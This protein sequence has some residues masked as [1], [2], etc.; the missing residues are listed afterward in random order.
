MWLLEWIRNLV[1]DFYNKLLSVLKNWVEVLIKYILW[2]V[3]CIMRLAFETC[4]A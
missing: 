4:S 2:I 1:I 3:Y